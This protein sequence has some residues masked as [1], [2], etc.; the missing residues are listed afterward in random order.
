M[1][2]KVLV[3]EMGRF[4][5]R[6]E[7]LD[8][9]WERSHLWGHESFKVLKQK[10]GTESVLGLTLDMRM[11]EKVNYP[12]RLHKRLKHLIG[13]RIGTFLEDRI[14]ESKI[15]MYYEFGI[16]STIYGSE[17]YESLFGDGAHFKDEQRYFRALSQRKSNVLEDG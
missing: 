12:Q 3:Q 16:F 11:L 15:Q 10:K 5:V 7:S 4:I 8:K 2:L 9:P 14:E 6:K 17:S 1:A 13:S